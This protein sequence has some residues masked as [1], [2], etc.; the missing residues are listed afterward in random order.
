MQCTRLNVPCHKIS[1]HMELSCLEIHV[2]IHCY[3]VPWIYI[4][5]G[6]FTDVVDLW[7]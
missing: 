2:S 5:S 3:R 6:Q 1:L 4:T 7:N